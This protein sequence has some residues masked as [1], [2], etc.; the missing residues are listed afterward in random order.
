[1]LWKITISS[2]LNIPAIS[3]TSQ[4]YGWSRYQLNYYQASSSSFERLQ[5]CLVFPRPQRNR[6][7]GM[8]G[9]HIYIDQEFKPFLKPFFFFWICKTFL[10][11]P[12]SQTLCKTFLYFQIC[13][14]YLHWPGIQ[15]P[16]KSLFCIW[17]QTLF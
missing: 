4:W 5:R 2:I 11:W 13:R 15:T 8:A 17:I 10:H 12:G 14:A 16:F 6:W 1:M 9:R 7:C 3:L